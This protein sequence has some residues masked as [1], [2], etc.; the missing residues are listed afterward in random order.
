M[1]PAFGVWFPAQDW[2]WLDASAES[3]FC[4]LLVMKQTNMNPT[5]PECIKNGLNIRKFV[6]AGR[7]LWRRRGGVLFGTNLT[8]GP[9][10]LQ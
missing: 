9:S 8:G 2:S 6:V 4:G 5:N 3:K 1:I 7:S 10:A